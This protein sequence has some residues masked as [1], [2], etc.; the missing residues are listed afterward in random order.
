MAKRHLK[1]APGA[2]NHPTLQQLLLAKLRVQEDFLL[3]SAKLED[4]LVKSRANLVQVTH[5]ELQEKG[6][7]FQL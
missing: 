5:H 2:A 1:A 7:V 6:F 4:L 3:R